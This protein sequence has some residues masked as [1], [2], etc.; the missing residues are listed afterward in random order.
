MSIDYVI[1]LKSSVILS[2]SNLNLSIYRDRSIMSIDYVIMLKSSDIL[3]R[4]NV[5]LSIYCVIMSSDCVIVLKVALSFQVLM[6]FA[7]VLLCSIR[8]LCCPKT[9]LS[10]SNRMVLL[11]RY[12][13][14]HSCRWRADRENG[15]AKS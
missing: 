12:D 10:C 7:I 9:M 4:S 11:T 3:S 2:R 6:S 13:V 1:M 5:N 8:M 15:G 14:I